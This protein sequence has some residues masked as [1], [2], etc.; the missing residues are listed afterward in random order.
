MTLF[1]STSIVGYIAIFDMVKVADIIR[2]RTYEPI[3]P[4][5][6]VSIIYYLF[7]LIV[8]RITDRVLNKLDWTKK[9][10]QSFG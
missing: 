10:E 7:G 9:G 4:L 6:S 2:S 5:V 1:K 3:I 8:I